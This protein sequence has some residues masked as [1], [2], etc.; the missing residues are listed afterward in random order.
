[1][2]FQSRESV[3]STPGSS[4][5]ARSGLQKFQQC[6]GVLNVAL[7]TKALALLSDLFDDLSLEIFGGSVG[8]VVAVSIFH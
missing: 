6:F 3:T 7:A 8:S 1:M 2:C 5:S 4:A